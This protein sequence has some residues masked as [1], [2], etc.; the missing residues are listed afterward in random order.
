MTDHKQLQQVFLDK[1][2]A[3]QVPVTVSLDCAAWQ[4]AGA[5]PRSDLGA[6]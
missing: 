2:A 1:L 6:S 3:D 5:A 4:Q